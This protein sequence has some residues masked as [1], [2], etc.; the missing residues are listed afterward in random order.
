M[1]ATNEKGKGVLK[2][3]LPFLVILLV[4]LFVFFLWRYYHPHRSMDFHQT[5]VSQL[6]HKPAPPQRTSILA[7]K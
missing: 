1:A 2:A 4:L 5:K 7:G 3:I 6:L